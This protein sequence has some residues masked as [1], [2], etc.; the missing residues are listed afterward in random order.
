M[1]RRDT[2]G[3]ISRQRLHLGDDGQGVHRPQTREPGV[4][5]E[6][7]GIWRARP[8]LVGGGQ[9]VHRPQT[10]EPGVGLTDALPPATQDWQALVAADYAAT[11]GMHPM[12]MPE[13]RRWF[14]VLSARLRHVRILHGDWRRAV[15]TGATKTLI[16]RE[17]KGVCG[18]FFDPPY[19]QTERNVRLY[20]SDQTQ[21]DVAADVRA[22]C[23]AHGDDPD[24][25]IVLA[26]FAGEGHE[27][28]DA[29]G[30]HVYEWFQ[31]GHLRGGMGNT[32][33]DGTHQQA[34]ERLWAS[35]HCLRPA[36]H[37]TRQLTL[38]L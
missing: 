30:W 14:H 28:L 38:M 16:V 20:T 4:G 25:R 35:P 11:E 3:G 31:A 36:S 1:V 19:A 24:Y 2:K 33:Q 12:T 13:L 22:W 23:L 15:T 27:V 17:G 7:D 18:L 5:R 8:Q 32:N 10:R 37:E 9:G 34:R 6:G 21:G 26:G 29:A